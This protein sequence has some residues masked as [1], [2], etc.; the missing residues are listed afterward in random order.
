MNDALLPPRCP[1][2]AVG[3]ARCRGRC[4]E[5]AARQAA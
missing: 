2:L 1:E 5:L 3:V 4:P